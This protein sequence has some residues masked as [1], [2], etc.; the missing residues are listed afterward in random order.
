MADVH[1]KK[2]RSYNA[3]RIKGKNTTAELI[4]RKFLFANGFR[5]RLHAKKLDGKKINGKP[6][7]VLSKYK[8]IVDVR[9]C[10]WHGHENCKF[11]A[12]TD[13]KGYQKRIADAKKRDARNIIEWEKAGYKV[14]VIWDRCQLEDKKKK[15]TVRK[16]TLLKLKEDILNSIP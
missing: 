2:T 9:G 4:V 11:G 8:T 16:K 15:S 5:Y 7:I 10:F 3:S 6:D 1:D 13:S 14:L 12:S